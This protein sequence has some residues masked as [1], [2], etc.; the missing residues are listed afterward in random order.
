LL[1]LILLTGVLAALSR[2]LTPRESQAQRRTQTV[3]TGTVVDA[4]GIGPPDWD[5]RRPE[6]FMEGLSRYQRLRLSHAHGNTTALPTDM[7]SP[8]IK[9]LLKEPDRLARS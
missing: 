7:S 9:K 8:P 1:T 5:A 4:A 6:P 2:P 3:S